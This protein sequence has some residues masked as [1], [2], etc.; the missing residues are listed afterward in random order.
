M[1]VSAKHPTLACDWGALGVWGSFGG[2]TQTH[3]ETNFGFSIPFLKGSQEEDDVVERLL[4]F[5]AAAYL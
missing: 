1:S 3:L 5:S 4:G 2:Y